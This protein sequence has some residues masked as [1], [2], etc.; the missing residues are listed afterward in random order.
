M[1]LERLADRNAQSLSTPQGERYLPVHQFIFDWKTFKIKEEE[2][3]RLPAIIKQQGNHWYGFGEAASKL[4]SVSLDYVSSGYVS[5]GERNKKQIKL[6]MAPRDHGDLVR[7]QLVSQREQTFL[8]ET[9]KIHDMQEELEAPEVVEHFGIDILPSLESRYHPEWEQLTET[10]VS[11]RFDSSPMENLQ[12]ETSHVQT[13][14]HKEGKEV[15][16]IAIPSNDD[17][18]SGNREEAPLPGKDAMSSIV[19]F[20]NELG[21]MESE[22]WSSRGFHLGGESRHAEGNT[23]NEHD[24]NNEEGKHNHSKSDGRLEIWCDPECSSDQNNDY[25]DGPEEQQS[26]HFINNIDLETPIEKLKELEKDL[27]E[28]HL[29]DLNH[30]SFDGIDLRFRNLIRL[31]GALRAF[32]E[33]NKAVEIRFLKTS[34]WNGLTKRSTASI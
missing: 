27:T 16:V 11:R 4:F 17:T 9:R 7:Q 26:Y 13:Q 34:R 33:T 14:S 24:S 6:T 2:D 3:R 1:E 18:D 31:K 19:A 20:I 32:L 30:H 22:S 10:Y 28:R 25:I 23:D 21:Q 8:N 12:R 29:E 15:N 5:L